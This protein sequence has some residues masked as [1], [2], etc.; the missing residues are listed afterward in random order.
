VLEGSVLPTGNQVRVNAQLIGADSGAHLWAEQFDT[1]RADLLQMQ[2]EIVTHL[3]RA[4]DI[5]LSE[6]EAARLKRT[7]PANPDAEDLAF[8]C[9]A[10]AEKG[11]FIGKEADAG[12]RLCEQ[13][14]A[15]DPNNVHALSLLSLKFWL[16]VAF[17]C[18]ADPKTDLERADELVSKALALDPNYARAHNIKAGIV[19]LQGRHDEAIAENERALALDPALLH[20]VAGLNWDYV[21]LGQFEKSLEYSDKAIR[22][23]PH[24]PS[25][26][27]WYR[28]RAAASFG[29]K[30]YDRAIEW[31]R[32]A[33][34]IKADNLWAYLNLIAALA[35]TGREA[36][37]HEALRNYLASVPS[38]PKTIAAWN[39]I[40]PPFTYMHSDP[41]F[42]DEWN[43]SIEG[44]R[45]AGLPEE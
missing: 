27:D 22:L 35:L 3:A 31:A 26:E 21:Y 14:L 1:P 43:R 39:A 7:P 12:Y 28:A 44:L 13:A 41:R 18:S 25:L 40:A 10:G 23:S 5:Q 11:G 37:A 17:C 6:A 30:Q 29:L 19:S 24:D 32:R 8:Q 16:P 4:M 36:E 20:A 34:A 15:A 33:I 9:D 42:L 45:K 38:G 2:D